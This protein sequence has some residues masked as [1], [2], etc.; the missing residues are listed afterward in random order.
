MRLTIITSVL[1]VSS[2]LVGCHKPDASFQTLRTEIVVPKDSFDVAWDE[3]LD[4]LAEHDFRP[5]YQNPRSGK[6]IST[7]TV[8]QQWFEFWRDDT[9]G[10]F[11]W[12]ESS[13]HTIRRRVEVDFVPTEKDY[14]ILLAVAVQRKTQPERQV[15]T[16]SGALQIYRDK[17]P[18]YTGEM[19]PEGTGVTW[20][21][22]DSDFRM[23]NYLA[24]GLAR[25]LGAGTE[26]VERPQPEPKPAAKDAESHADAQA[27][28][29]GHE[30]TPQ[31]QTPAAQ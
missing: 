29:D 8:S 10:G 20:V 7:P 30:D 19:A 27:T 12:L 16:A 13:M 17:L 3:T 9:Q 25:R 28:T 11:E 1:L 22:V 23:E 2:I 31:S 6:I 26:T 14:R 15:T 18:V 5:D 24:N 4:F 21:D